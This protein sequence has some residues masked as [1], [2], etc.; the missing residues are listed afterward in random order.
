M[1]AM[2]PLT[3]PPPVDCAVLVV[4]YNSAAFVGD[5]L[6]SLPAAAGGLSLRTVVVDNG[7]SDGTVAQLRSR[8]EVHCIE[9]GANLG[10]AGGINLAQRHAGPCARVLVLNP[11]L[12]LE[13]GA[14]A[15]LAVALQ[16]PAA[17]LAVP[18][19]LDSAG[20]LELTLRREPSLSRAIGDALFGRRL[21]RRPGW[22]SE[23]VLD[24]RAYRDPHPVD[25]AGG[26]AA[27]VSADCAGAVGPWDESFF[28]YSEEVDYAARVRAAGFRVEYVP[29]ARVRHHEGGSGSSATLTALQAVNRVRYVA[30]RRRRGSGAFRAAVALHEL[31]RAYDPAHRFALRTVLRRSRWSELLGGPGPTQSDRTHPVSSGAQNG[32]E[33]ELNRDAPL[34]T[35]VQCDP[36]PEPSETAL[37]V[38]K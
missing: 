12:V 16:D 15:R 9:A 30:K 23:T 17:G 20:R 21:A 11:D 13:A 33:L 6:D 29:A 5:L 24:E 25:W 4:T 18:M 37:D 8:P 31:L 1:L 32:Q 10:Y 35:A 28:L 34:R 36:V 7:S 19:I 3:D 38:R 2:N 22:L 26:A 14:I 27:M